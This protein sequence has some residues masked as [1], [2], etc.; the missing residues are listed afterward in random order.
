MAALSDEYQE[1]LKRELAAQYVSHLPPLLP[2][3]KSSQQNAEKQ[4]NR[5]LSAFLLHAK[6]GISARAA[7]RSVVDDF[8]DNGIDALYF[9]AKADHRHTAYCGGT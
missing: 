6:L 7:A 3:K 4:V 9:D 8:E 2:N 5:A 1:I